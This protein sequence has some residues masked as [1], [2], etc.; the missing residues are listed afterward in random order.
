MFEAQVG[1]GLAIRKEVLRRRGVLR[2]NVTR[3]AVR[4]VDAAMS[5][6]LDDLF[7]RTGVR[8]GPERLDVAALVGPGEPDRV[9]T[10]R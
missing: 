1:V 6:E 9:N 5:E 3:G 10:S 7:E 8:P 2:S 4:Q